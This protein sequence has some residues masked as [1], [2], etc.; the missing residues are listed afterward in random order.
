MEN[1]TPEFLIPHW[2]KSS[3]MLFL[4][5]R[6]SF[7]KRY[8]LKIY[9]SKTGPSALLGIMAHKALEEYF[10]GFDEE[11]AVASGL[12]VIDTYVGSEINWGKTGSREKTMNDYAQA[13]KFYFE[14]M[15]D[16]YNTGEVMQAEL[17]HTAFV[18]LPDGRRMAI[19]AKAHV[20]LTWRNKRT[21]KL[22]IHDAKFVTSYTGEDERNW[23]YILQAMFNYFVV[24]DKYGEAPSKMVFRECKISKNKNGLQQT[25]DYEIV[26][27]EHPEYFDVFYRLYDD[28]TKEIMRTDVAFLPNPQD[29]FEGENSMEIYAQQLLSIDLSDIE[30]RHK[31]EIKEIRQVQYRPSAH[32]KEENKFISPEE[33]I[34]LKFAEFGIPIEMKET[35]QSPH[36]TLYTATPSRGVRMSTIEKHTDDLKIALEATHI[37]IL[38][39][40][41]GTAVI[42]VE[43]ANKERRFVPYSALEL[44]SGEL[45]VPMGIDSHNQ[46]ITKDLRD[47]PHLLVAGTTGSGKSVFLNVLIKSI[48]AQM[49]STDL[50]LV[51][52]DMKRV[53]LTDHAGLPHLETL[54]ITDEERAAKALKWLVDEMERRY[55]IFE[56]ARVKNIKEYQGNMK[57]LVV[58]IDEFADL[59]L[60][61]FGEFVEPAIVRLAQKARAVGIHLVVATQRP[62]VNVVTGLLKANIATR[63]CFMTASQI[64]SKVVLDTVGSEELT[65]KGDCLFLDPSKV[66]LQRLQAFSYE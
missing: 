4:S 58:V 41:P 43:V 46:T 6:L 5:N 39:P 55:E 48:T 66:G 22:E 54:V 7:K 27:D 51:L 32:D 65:G 12:K 40:I 33:K 63:L 15:P 26:F 11:V 47:M 31:M 52:I 60:G 20:D 2:S 38:A 1:I 37:R 36:V 50:G 49:P 14:E 45:M 13:V 19:P 10:N 56:G 23:G 25:E 3:M 57:Y 62:S 64:D 9:D 28:C 29:M 34:R 42:G 16:Y 35:I 59:I 61:K 53:E 18:D 24:K 8:I 21:G 17:K 30:V 44:P